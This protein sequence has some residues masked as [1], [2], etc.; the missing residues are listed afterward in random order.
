MT[1]PRTKK[2]TNAWEPLC[3]HTK[4]ASASP[5]WSRSYSGRKLTFFFLPPPFALF[6]ALQSA[7]RWHMWALSVR[8]SVSLYCPRQACS[9]SIPVR[10]QCLV[11]LVL[12]ALLCNN[13]RN[14]DKGRHTSAAW[15]VYIF[16]RNVIPPGTTCWNVSKGAILPPKLFQTGTRIHFLYPRAT[17]FPTR[18][19]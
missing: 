14:N 2:V 15:L 12:F 4:A 19:Y 16:V 3:D 18:L 8:I 13:N 5:G 1:N 7:P 6:L 10:V 9:S 17:R 11:Y